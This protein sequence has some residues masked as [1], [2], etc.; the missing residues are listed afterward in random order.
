MVTTKPP[1]RER[2]AA[3]IEASGDTLGEELLNLG[4][5]LAVRY[6]RQEGHPRGAEVL[7]GL[8]IELS[9]GEPPAPSPPK[10]TLP[11]LEETI[12]DH[13]TRAVV[14][15]GPDPIAWG[16]RI[17]LQV[18]LAHVKGAHEADIFTAGAAGAEELVEGLRGEGAR[19]PEMCER[20]ARI[21]AAHLGA[22]N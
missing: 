14:Q 4:V 3:A 17:G 19:A 13:L 6:L 15:H 2:L 10:L 20:I 9:H 1:P 12:T 18:A 5:A 11:Q 7:S 21:H 22:L 16:V 8:R